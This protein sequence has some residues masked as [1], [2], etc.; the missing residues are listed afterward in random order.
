MYC[1]IHQ[2]L[3][4]NNGCVEAHVNPLTVD[5]VMIPAVPAVKG[6]QALGYL[7]G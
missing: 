1:Q 4:N 7:D 2:P 5:G 3:H 6:S